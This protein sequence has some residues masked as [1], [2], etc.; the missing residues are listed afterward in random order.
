MTISTFE[1]A[2]KICQLGNWQI[3]NLK[4]QKI[5][6][7]AHLLYIGRN[8]GLP[9]I[10]ESFEAWDYGPVVPSLYQK[11][12]FFGGEMIDNIFYDINLD[13]RNTNEFKTIEEVCENL[14]NK[15]AGELVSITHRNNGA[16]HKSYSI[17]RGLKISNESILQEYN[18][19]SK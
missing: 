12:K 1:A 19:Y 8:N 2:K 11:V 13:G 17:R 10:D 3:T 5:L 14:K 15:T 6:Y 9:L 4:L 16:W 18:D 7:I